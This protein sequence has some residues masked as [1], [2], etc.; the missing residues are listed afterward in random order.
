[1]GVAA[2]SFVVAWFNPV[3]AGFFPVCP[4]F[5]LT[6]LHCP[7]CGLTRGFHALFHG[8]FIGA[9][10]YNILIPLYVLF[11]G[12]LTLSLTFTAIRGVGLSWNFLKPWMVYG[13]LA[14]SLTFA[15]LRN[16]PYF[17]LNLL[18]P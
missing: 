4:L 6:G 17:P 11:F 16:L 12:Y 13:F 15:V 10:D 3:K 18:A 14:V 1:M 5:Q 7:G 8:D 9:I 2:G